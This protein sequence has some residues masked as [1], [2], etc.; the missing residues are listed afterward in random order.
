MDKSDFFH[1]EAKKR[2]N[3]RYAMLGMMYQCAS[4][5]NIDI[6]SEQALNIVQ[7]YLTS[8]TCCSFFEWLRINAHKLQ[9]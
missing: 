4:Y 7:T 1:T 3:G 9:R 6:N 5:L 8:T 2:D